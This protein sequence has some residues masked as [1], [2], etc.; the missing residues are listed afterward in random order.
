MG[1]PALSSEYYTVDQVLAIPDDGNRRELVYGELLVS[2]APRLLH[3]RVVGRLMRILAEYCERD[4]LGEVLFSPAD[5]TWGRLDVLAQPD[6][7]VIGLADAGVRTWADVRHIELVAEVTSPSTRHF[8]RFQKRTLYRDR[9]VGVYWIVDPDRGLAEVWTPAS[10]SPTIERETL[11]WHP[12]GAT[13]PLVIV[14]ASLL[15]A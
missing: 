13:M 1:M 14:L 2:P 12:D 7:F 4:G 6:V 15:A 5:L 11:T 8:D 9:Q 3:Q 10:Q